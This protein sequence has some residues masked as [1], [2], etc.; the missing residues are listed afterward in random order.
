M[1]KVVILAA[2][3]FC[4]VNLIAQS[5]NVGIGVED[6]QAKLHISGDVRVDDKLEIKKKR[7]RVNS[8]PSYILKYDP[9]YVNIFPKLSE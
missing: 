8:H 1:K 7:K 9:F 5:G 2:Y 4:G 6:P 3:I